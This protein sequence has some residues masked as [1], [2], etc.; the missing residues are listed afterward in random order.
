M[1]A[2]S[3]SLQG[4]DPGEELDRFLAGKQ[5]E[6]EQVMSLL[7]FK[8]RP[9]KSQAEEKSFVRVLLQVKAK[10][11][12]QRSQALQIG[13]GM[14]PS[15]SIQENICVMMEIQADYKRFFWG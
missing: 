12:K 3:S 11:E 13:L 1:G 10:V 15:E 7:D 6:E 9:V 8:I 14:E 2:G 5:M 4:E